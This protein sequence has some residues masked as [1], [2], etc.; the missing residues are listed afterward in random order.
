[1]RPYFWGQTPSHPQEHGMCCPGEK[2]SPN[3]SD[4]CLFLRGARPSVSVA[5]RRASK[6]LMRP[7]RSASHPHNWPRD[8]MATWLRPRPAFFALQPFPPPRVGVVRR[9]F[10]PAPRWICEFLAR[11]ARAGNP[12]NF[13]F[14]RL[15]KVQHGRETTQSRKTVDDQTLGQLWV[16]DF[17][18]CSGFAENWL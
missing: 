14:T 18:S 4:V 11:G 13:A 3:G 5:K 16:L 7:R 8:A 10:A 12:A 9:F 1:M 2:I 6:E 17:R 15:S